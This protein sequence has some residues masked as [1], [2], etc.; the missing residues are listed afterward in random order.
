[1]LGDSPLATIEIRTG[2]LRLLALTLE[3]LCICLQAPER[4][5]QELGFPISAGLVTEPV[6]RALGLKVDRMSQVALEEHPWHTYWLMVIAAEPTG[7]G[8][9][10]F[11]GEPDQQGEIEI[12]FGIVPTCRNR[13]YTTEATQALIAWAFQDPACQ[14]V[15]ADSAGD[16]LASSRVLTKVGMHIFRETEETLSWRI[17]RET[18][19]APYRQGGPIS[20]LGDFGL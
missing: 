7:V 16:N 4:L 8:L 17:G 9:I 18:H 20:G 11:K 19:A 3:Q 13:G 5:G 14:A 1:M 12:G 10:G 6:R 15:V 2:R